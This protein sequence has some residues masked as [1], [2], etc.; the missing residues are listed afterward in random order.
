MIFFLSSYTEKSAWALM[1]NDNAA[2][3]NQRKINM[4]CIQ[5]NSNDMNIYEGYSS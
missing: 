3:L 4:L 2:Y 1:F 5:D